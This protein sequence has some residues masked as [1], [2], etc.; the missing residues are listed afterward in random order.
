MITNKSWLEG[1]TLHCKHK[2]KQ[3]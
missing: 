2:A 3:S 1:S